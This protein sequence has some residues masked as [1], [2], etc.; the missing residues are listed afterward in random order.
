MTE[1]TW[2]SIVLMLGALFLFGSSFASYRLGA[3]K[4]ITL[5]LIWLGIFV[6]LVLIAE[7]VGARLPN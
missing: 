5:A 4:T 1:G 2:L 7:L 6:V 3:E